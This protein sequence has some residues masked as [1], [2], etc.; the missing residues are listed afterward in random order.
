MNYYF[1]VNGYKEAGIVIANN[2][3]SAKH[4]VEMSQDECSFI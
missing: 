4:K 3:A 2:I 1:W